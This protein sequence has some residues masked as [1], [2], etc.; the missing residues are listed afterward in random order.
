MSYFKTQ[1]GDII[2]GENDI[3][4]KCELMEIVHLSRSTIQRYMKQGLPYILF[5][6][7]VA[8]FNLKEAQ[9]WL[10]K[11]KSLPSD[12]LRKR[13]AEHSRMIRKLKQ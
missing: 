2:D 6:N 12:Y 8:G 11:H 13:W 1:D 7:N 10:E 9:E 4:S 3:L 5:D